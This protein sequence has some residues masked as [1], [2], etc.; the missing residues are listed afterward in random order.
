MRSNAYY[1]HVR[2][3]VASRQESTGYLFI[4]VLVPNR[5][6]TRKIIVDFVLVWWGLK[7]EYIAHPV[8]LKNGVF[9]YI[10]SMDISDASVRYL[11][12]Y[13]RDNFGIKHVRV[14]TKADNAPKINQLLRTKTLES[15]HLS[16]DQIA[17][18]IQK[19]AP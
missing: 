11:K 13:L 3:V 9:Y 17:Q 6:N 5:E 1:D 2:E 15:Q 8:T 7:R 18:E 16:F 14:R 10:E 19:I 4:Q 12:R